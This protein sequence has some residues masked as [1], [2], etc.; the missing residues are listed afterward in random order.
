MLVVG[1]V[2][3]VVGSVFRYWRPPGERLLSEHFFGSTE[4]RYRALTVIVVIAVLSVP[5]T[6]WLYATYLTD[7]LFSYAVFG[8][9]IAVLVC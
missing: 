6:F 3:V 5:F 1:A 4:G 2:A 8:A 9:P 7:R